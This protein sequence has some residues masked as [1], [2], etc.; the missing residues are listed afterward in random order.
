MRLRS[1]CLI[2][3]S[4]PLTRL[5][6]VLRFTVKYPFPFFPL[7]C[8]NPRK[9]NVSGLP[10]P[11]RFRFCSAYRPNSIR[12]VLS[13]CSSNPNFLPHDQ[14]DHGNLPRHS[15]ACH[16]RLPSDFSL[17]R[18]QNGGKISCYL[19]RSV[20]ILWIK[21]DRRHAGMAAP[22]VFFRQ[23]SKVLVRGCLVPGI[24]AQ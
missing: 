14:G 16:R 2:C 23:G 9:S 8:V 22:T 20:E 7:I 3:C 4:L 18:S 24:R 5:R 13:G 10:S 12:R 21:R 19:S 17:L 15:Q 11:L 1:C 6:I